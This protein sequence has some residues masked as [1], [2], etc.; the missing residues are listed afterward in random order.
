MTRIAGYADRVSVTPG[1]TINFMV[2]SEAPSYKCDI[3]RLIC[4]DENPD[5]PGVK[6]QVV[7]T[8]AS[9]TYKGR[10][11]VCYDGSFMEVPAHPAIQGLESFT[12]QAFIWP[13]TPDRGTQALI[14]NW[15]DRDKA[16][17][18]LIITKQDGSLALCLG[19]GDG[20]IEVTA[21]N[22]PLIP[23]QWYFVA[24]TYNAE[25]QADHAGAAAAQRLPQRQRRPR[26][27][28]EVGAQRAGQARRTAHHGRLL[29]ACR[30]G[31]HGLRRLLQRAHRQPARRQPRADPG[32][33]GACQDPPGGRRARHLHR[34]C[35]GLLPGHQDDD[36]DRSLRQRLA[37]QPRQPADPRRHRLVLGRQRDELAER[38][39]AVRRDPLPRGRRLRRALGGRFLAHLPEAAEERRL[40]R[41]APRRR[42]RRGIH[43]LRRA[44]PAR[45]AHREDL[46]PAADRELHGLRQ[47]QHVHQHGRGADSRRPAHGA[48]REEICS[49]ASIG[50]TAPRSTTATSTAAASATPR[51]SGRS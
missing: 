49:A 26:P 14:S 22:R 35:L 10:K 33:D 3:V 48:E 20:N 42:R 18:A 7:R 12:F 28:E 9:G 40:C 23:H 31:P 34:R 6:E 43:P 45:R 17:A 30:Q 51:G 29:P 46:L 19:D 38:A 47:H 32:G 15:R 37:R 5:G 50:N 4:G 16:G 2:S 21:T 24:A 41:E 27:E 8:S 25:T 1:E 39:G 44:R 11:Q 13:T 36:G